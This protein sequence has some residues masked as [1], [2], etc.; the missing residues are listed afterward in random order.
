MYKWCFKYGEV[1]DNSLNYDYRVVDF[2][3]KKRVLYL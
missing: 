1:F 2:K 3:S